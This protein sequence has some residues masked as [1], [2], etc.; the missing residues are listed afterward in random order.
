[1][2][3]YI[4]SPLLFLLVYAVGYVLNALTV[5]GIWLISNRRKMEVRKESDRYFCRSCGTELILKTHGAPHE[6]HLYWH[7]AYMGFG[8]IKGTDIDCDNSHKTFDPSAT[9]SP[10]K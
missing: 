5:G 6:R 8:I 7:P 10:D 3:D 1:M 9:I 2:P 4:K